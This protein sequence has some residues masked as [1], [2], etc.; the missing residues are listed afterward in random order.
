MWYI[1]ADIFY[2]NLQNAKVI[3]KV[4]MANEITPMCLVVIWVYSKDH[5]V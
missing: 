1:Y 2:V 4:G 3:R 5:S